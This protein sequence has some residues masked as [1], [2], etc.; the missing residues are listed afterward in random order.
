MVT[1]A[2]FLWENVDPEWQICQSSKRSWTLGISCKI[3]PLRTVRDQI[4]HSCELDS[5]LGLL[6]QNPQGYGVGNMAWG[7]GR[8]EQ[9]LCLFLLFLGF[10]PPQHHVLPCSPQV[11]RSPP[12]FR[13]KA[14]RIK[15]FVCSVETV[16]LGN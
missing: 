9:P 16:S 12:F 14:H 4:Q 1:G 3:S 10:P 6:V 11:L 8:A 13:N 2:K 7:G 5:A 15:K